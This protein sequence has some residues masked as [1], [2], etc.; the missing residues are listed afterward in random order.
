MNLRD[1]APNSILLVR[2]SAIGDIVMTSGLLPCLCAAWPE[3]RIGW[4]TEETNADLLRYNPRLA[5]LHLWP[6]RHWRELR[7]TGK[8]RELLGAATELIRELRAE[9]YDW[10]LDLQGLMK[11]GLWAR[12]AGGRQWIGLGSREGSQWLMHEVLDR[13]TDDPRMGREYR[14]LAAWLGADAGNFAPDIA[15]S[16]EDRDSASALLRNL[17]VTGTYTVFAPFTTR[18]QKHWLDARWAE[19]AVRLEYPVVLLGGS[20]NR[21]RA[22]LIRAGGESRILNLTGRTSLGQCAA[23]IEHAKLLIGVDTGLTH[24][25]IALETPTLALFGSTRPYLDAGRANARVLYHSLPCSPCRRRPTCDGRF[26]C[27]A[28]HTAESVANTA[29]RLLQSRP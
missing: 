22:G 1:T 27:M 10:V 25:G 8:Y 14:K 12:L 3:I 15:I 29:Q 19:L 2:L 4:L 17:G 6:R 11:S 23:I 26:D 21:E 24:L 28:L 16:Q 18:P 7:R 5:R 13:Q 9:Q 20:G